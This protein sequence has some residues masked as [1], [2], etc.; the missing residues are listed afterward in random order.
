MACGSASS[1]L[2]NRNG[3]GSAA[4]SIID[5]IVKPAEATGGKTKCIECDGYE[6]CCIPIPCTVICLPL[7]NPVK[8]TYVV[9]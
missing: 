8:S 6:C 4:T 9:V 2:I 3:P 1:G 5:S 7:A